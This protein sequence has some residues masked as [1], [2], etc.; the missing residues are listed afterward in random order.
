VPGAHGILIRPPETDPA[1][2]PPRGP[3]TTP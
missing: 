1:T 2:R 3:P